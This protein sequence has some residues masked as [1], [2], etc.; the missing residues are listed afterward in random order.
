MFQF[1]HFIKYRDLKIKKRD[2]RGFFTY[3]GEFWCNLPTDF[4]DL[5]FMNTHLFTKTRVYFGNGYIT[6]YTPSAEV[7]GC[8]L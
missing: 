8:C 3:F 4:V 6:W 5:T 1:Y 2:V 7:F